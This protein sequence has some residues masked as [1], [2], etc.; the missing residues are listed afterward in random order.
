MA[1]I[2][3]GGPSSFIGLLRY[4][5]EGWEKGWEIITAI[6]LADGMNVL[7]S[8]L[9]LRH[10]GCVWK[11]RSRG[12]EATLREGFFIESADSRYLILDNEA[13]LDSNTPL[14]N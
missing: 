12:F 4:I 7:V 8:F 3:T 1:G 14:V 2:S 13:N 9:R 11:A 6:H 10:S 5:E